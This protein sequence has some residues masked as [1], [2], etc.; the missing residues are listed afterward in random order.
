VGETVGHTVGHPPVGQMPVGHPVGHGHGGWIVSV[1]VAQPVGHAQLA[2]ENT[3]CAAPSSQPQGNVMVL[4]TMHS[5]TMQDLL[6]DEGQQLGAETVDVM[7]GQTG[8]STGLPLTR[9]NSGERLNVNEESFGTRLTSL[10]RR[11]KRED[12]SSRGPWLSCEKGGRGEG[13]GARQAEDCRLYA[14]TGSRKVLM[15]V[16]EDGGGKG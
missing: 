14:G 15:G 1:A 8:G 9:L 4:S 16:D 13:G 3:V 10:A 11:R 6:L 2:V 12:G 7:V 5:G